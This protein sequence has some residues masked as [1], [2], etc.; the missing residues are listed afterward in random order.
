MGKVLIKAVRGGRVYQQCESTTYGTV[1]DILSKTGQQE[2]F[3]KG[4]SRHYLIDFHMVRMCPLLLAGVS[5]K[6]ER[7]KVTQAGAFITVV[8]TAQYTN[9]RFGHY[10]K[11]THTL[12][13]AVT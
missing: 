12:S 10:S 5:V 13:R 9:A 4:S 3:E 11:R 8:L 6:D 7:D 2:Q 1:I